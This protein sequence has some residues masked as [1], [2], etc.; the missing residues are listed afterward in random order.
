MVASAFFV[1]PVML[2]V[3]A[4]A[5]APVVIHLIM[6]SRPR[7]MPF[8]ALRFV[9]KTHMANLKALRLKH[10]ILLAM[11]VA[12]VVLIAFLLARPQIPGA[13]R[14]EPH[15]QPAAVVVL[16]DNSASMG[17]RRRGKTLL[18]R[19]KRLAAQVIDSLP[20]GSYAMVL[21]TDGGNHPTVFLS[22]MARVARQIWDVA[23]GQGNTA[24]TAHLGAALAH[25]GRSTLP[26]RALYVVSDMTAQAWRGT[27]ET[28]DKDVRFVMLNCRPGQDVNFALG[29]LQLSRARACV[30]Q[31]VQ[32]ETVVRAGRVGGEARVLL[33]LDGKRMREQRLHVPADGGRATVSMSVVPGRQG[34]LHG[35]V[36]IDQEDPLATDNERY[37][38]LHVRRPP[39]VLIIRDPATVGR[40][41]ATTFLM[42]N[43]VAPA[44][45]RGGGGALRRRRVA[46]N[47]LTEGDLDRAD[48]ALLSNVSVVPPEQWRMLGA[49]VRRGGRLWVVAGPLVSA[50]A[51][52]RPEARRVMPASLRPHEVLTEPLGWKADDV[53]H[54]LF[55]PFA[56]GEN[57]PLSEVRCMR[58]MGVDP[59]GDAEVV[60]RYADGVPAAV[61]RPVGDGAVLLWNFSP[62]RSDSNLA[63]LGQFPILARRAVTVLLAEEDVR[64]T[65]IIGRRVSVDFPRG[66]AAASVTVSTPGFSGETV[67]APDPGGRAVTLSADRVGHWDVWFRQ[68]DKAVG[69]GFSVNTDPAE[70][71]TTPV[72]EARLKG[73]FPPENLL[74]ADSMEDIKQARL[75]TPGTLD[76]VIPILLALLVLLVGESFFGNRFYRRGK[77]TE[78]EASEVQT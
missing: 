53:R 38:T 27:F 10:L 25:L 62:A 77:A 8:P 49:Y 70:S 71:D 11:R 16:V 58:R 68:G 36:S 24:V 65:H 78:P 56:T 57:P 59:A 43:A 55:E 47:R 35:Q 45:R 9:R 29:D 39:E 30:G 66:M 19:G 60:L 31:E 51:Y 46:A 2:G 12:V 61:L 64:T 26:R 32:I 37:F 76:L 44:T 42:A 3:S 75:G 21:Q 23:A 20:S 4:A 63:G 48:L 34:V 73:M 67:V 14:G 50:A 7:T 22:D 5:V 15:H 69:R 33:E 54:P 17:Y 74:V 1:F 40:G 28:A 72:Q 52:N 6:R 13:S 41:D 18:D